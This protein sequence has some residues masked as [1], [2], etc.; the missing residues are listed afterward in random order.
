MPY[1]IPHQALHDPATPIFGA[2]TIVT[3]NNTTSGVVAVPT[4]TTEHD[5]LV[6]WIAKTEAATF[7]GLTGWTQTIAEES[8]PGAMLYCYEKE[9]SAADAVPGS[10]TPA[11]TGADD[12]V[13]YMINVDQCGASTFK[14]VDAP[15]EDVWSVAGT[16]LSIP[17]IGGPKLATLNTTDV[18]FIDRDVGD[19]SLYRWG[20]GTWAL[21]GTALTISPV[22][23]PAIATLNSTDVAFYDSTLGSRQ[24]RLYRWN[25]GT[26]TWSQ[27]GTGLSSIALTGA[28]AL[29]ALNSTD[30][31]FTNGKL[32]EIRLYRWSAGTET[33]SQVGAGL[34]ITGMGNPV[35]TTLNSTDVAYFDV[36]LDELRLY[37]WNSGT[38]TWSL[39]GTGLSIGAVLEPGLTS[40]NS[41]DVVF[42]YNGITDE[43]RLYRWDA[44][45]ETWSEV[46]TG[47]EIGA[48]IGLQSISA[49]SARDFAF[50]DADLEELRYYIRGTD[51]PTCPA[52][53]SGSANNLALRAMVC[54]GA[55][56]VTEPAGTTAVG[57]TASPNNELT[58]AL[59]YE[60]VAA[61]G[62]DIGA[63]AF[64]LSAAQSW[65]AA[66]VLLRAGD[67][68]PVPVSLILTLFD[69]TAGTNIGD[70]TSNGGLSAAFDG[71][72][73]Q[74]NGACAA[75]I[76]TGAC[77][78]G[79]NLGTS[80]PI[81]NVVVYPS[82]DQGFTGVATVTLNLR[83]NTTAPSSSSDGTLLGTTG[84]I[85][86]TTTEQTINSS[87]T[88]TPYQ[89][90]WVELVSS[91][92]T[93][94]WIAELKTYIY[95]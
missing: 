38:E 53:S 23:S 61:A 25:S 6:L 4:G 67:E 92:G 29:A 95:V 73:S 17:S 54:Q 10:Y 24:L 44:G 50:V 42:S 47:T 8:A 88:T 45:T 37:R 70:M 77:F 7:T 27:V 5:R 26:E 31:A 11:W 19:L 87:D 69:R 94:N 22:G 60:A 20:A 14:G 43:F 3:V 72:T 76:A 68:N 36:D 41:T 82:S 74:T 63:G 51:A 59:A 16:G 57:A 46:G 58:F 52:L 9:A 62:T 48:S 90:V 85:S 28:T 1:Y 93:N 55:P 12:A 75:G 86:D 81:G 2:V 40:L 13:I 34:P 21:V 35:L 79:K 64:A 83:A 56:T 71:T 84:S 33:W 80:T 32:E 15:A 89:Y 66:S 78:V 39:V 65:A 18:A 49:L 30:V 91:A